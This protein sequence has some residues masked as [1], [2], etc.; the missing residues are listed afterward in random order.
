MRRI[1]IVAMAG[2]LLIA[3]WRNLVEGSFGKA[4][5]LKRSED[6]TEEYRYLY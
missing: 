3:L 1:G 4:L 2:K 6:K 5:L